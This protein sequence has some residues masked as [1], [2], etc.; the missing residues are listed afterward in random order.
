M[1]DRARNATAQCEQPRAR[2]VQRS[3]RGIVENDWSGA[4]I[5]GTN[6]FQYPVGRQVKNG[7]AA[8]AR[9]AQSALLPPP[10]LKI[11]S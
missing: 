1:P 3:S 6:V 5:A 7:V 2:S 4:G 8:I 11:V 9:I 10:R